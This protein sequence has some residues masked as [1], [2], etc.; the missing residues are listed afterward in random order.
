[1]SDINKPSEIIQF[2]STEIRRVWDD[3]NQ[4]WFFAVVDAI[5]VLT[6]S[7]RP[8]KYWSDLRKRVKKQSGVEL[9]DFCGKFPLKNPKNN[10]TY[11]TD[12][13]NVEGLFRIIQSI[14]S[15]KAEPFKLWLARLGRERL[16]E[17]SDPQIA[18]ERLRMMYL[19]M[20]HDPK[21]V[22]RRVLA[23]EVNDNLIS[24]WEQRGVEGKSDQELLMDVI[25][26]GAF[27][28]TTTEH[29]AI[30]GLNEAD[31][32]PD[33][34]TATELVFKMLGESSAEA[35]AKSENA[36]GLDDLEKAARA[37]G[38]VA[39][40]AR[41]DLELRTGEPVVSSDNALPKPSESDEIE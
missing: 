39:G 7:E 4:E 41:K 2:E 23:I 36:Q 38:S 34:L 21:W 35:V 37:G 33:N 22:E 26:K 25:S 5:E 31:D 27:D 40:R 1:M 24:E 17:A 10:R 15:K 20:G 16:E 12:C 14:P 3:E 9:S 13:A 19:A 6:E 18:I 30:K 8:S 11:Q 29:K 32:L 28:L